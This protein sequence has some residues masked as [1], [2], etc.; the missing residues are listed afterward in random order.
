ADLEPVGVV[1]RVVHVEHSR[2]GVG[3]ALTVVERDPAVGAIDDEAEHGA[4]P[5]PRPLDVD[6][7]DP[8]VCERGA[9]QRGDAGDVVSVHMWG[10]PWGRAGYAVR[11][12]TRLLPAG[13]GATAREPRAFSQATSSVLALKIEL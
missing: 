4:P 11:G 5:V 6:E 1:D 3:R 2:R 7:L 9:Q 13:G 8:Q 10:M 12:V